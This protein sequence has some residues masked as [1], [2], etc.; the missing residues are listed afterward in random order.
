MLNRLSCPKWKY[1][2]HRKE[3]SNMKKKLLAVLLCLAMLVSMV[4]CGDKG[5]DEG[6]TKY[7]GPVA[8]LE[9]LADYSTCSLVKNPFCKGDK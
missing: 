7:E 3:F 9:Q 6:E 4:A 5:A 1:G 2:R 8:T